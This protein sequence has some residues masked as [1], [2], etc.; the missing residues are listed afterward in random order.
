MEKFNDLDQKI[1][2][3]AERIKALREMEG[4][5]VSVMAEK[6]GV[7]VEEYVKCEALPLWA[8]T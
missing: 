6:T 4:V 5:D 7:S 2:V 1:K 8:L 3:M